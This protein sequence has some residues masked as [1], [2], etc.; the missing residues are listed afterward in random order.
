ML[1]PC[2]FYGSLQL[3]EFT[4]TLTGTREF[5]LILLPRGATGSIHDKYTI[6]SVLKK[7]PA[8]KI[9]YTSS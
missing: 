7:R 1:N 5:G 6:V 9:K 4:F 8:V 2:I 3:A